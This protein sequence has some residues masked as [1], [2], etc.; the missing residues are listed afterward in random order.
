MTT[1]APDV[2]R[3]P[4]EGL[5]A[6]R[7]SDL[8]TTDEWI[9]QLS[10]AEIDEL[11]NALATVRQHGTSMLNVGRDDFPLPTLGRELARIADELETGRGFVLIRG[12]PI[13]RYTEADASVIY[14][15]LGQHLGIPVSQNAAGHL[16]GHV[17]D[18]GRKF[19]DP[20]VRGYQT[21]IHLPYHTDSSDVVG[22]LCLRPARTGG[23]STI[24]SSAAIYNEILAQRPDL[25]ERLYQPYFFDHRGEEQPG[26]C[27]YYTAP[28]ACWRNGQLSIRHIRGYIESAQRFPEVPRLERADIEMLDLIDSLANSPEFRLD[29]DFH[30]GDMQFL[31]NYAILHSR[32]EYED[33]TEPA[34]KR[35]LL[36]LWLTLRQG[37]ELD[38]GFISSKRTVT[39][40]GR[41]G[42][43]PRDNPAR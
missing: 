30:P 2:L 32:T 27:P 9:Y 6:W 26:E 23:L 20:T 14:W 17:R 33:F 16:L 19:S 43:P 29:M 15:G 1:T 10:T 42:V 31:N 21:T 11:E 4:Y 41:G 40:D 35:H 39:G 34:L 22:L 5:A 13:E 7:G 25:I 36:R 3:E 18:T 24:V 37:R 8:G 28:L 38:P 12:L